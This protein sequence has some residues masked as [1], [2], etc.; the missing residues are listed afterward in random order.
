MT[1]L[2]P[3]IRICKSDNLTVPQMPLGLIIAYSF[4]NCTNR[5]QL[6]TPTHAHVHMHTHLG[7]TETTAWLTLT[8]HGNKSTLKCHLLL[9][10]FLLLSLI[11]RILYNHSS[12]RILF[13]LYSYLCKMHYSR[14]RDNSIAFS[15]PGTRIM[16]L[17]CKWTIVHIR[18]FCA[19]D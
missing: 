6:C 16:A 17:W 3:I 4:Y 1:P 12:E 9:F 2:G 15:L 18:H 13:H 5:A 14:Q 7:K 10:F 19:L 11:D 8:L